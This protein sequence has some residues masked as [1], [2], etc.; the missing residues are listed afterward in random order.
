MRISCPRMPTVDWNKR[1]GRQI[2]EHVESGQ[3]FW[4]GCQWGDP[5]QLATLSAVA[6]RYIT[7]N[8]GPDTVA[9]E[10]GPGGGRWTQFLVSARELVLVDLNPEF[11]P[12][13]EERF[14][15]APAALRFYATRDSELDGIDSASI[16]F[17][18]SFGVFVHIDPD[19]IRG[20]LEHIA[21]VVRPGGLAIVQYADKTKKVAQE[22]DS[23]SDMNAMKMEAFA[24]PLFAIEGH[25]TTL[26]SHSNIIL[27]RR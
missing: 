3:D 14:K 8:V 4:W 15:D 20:Y 1:W 21:R 27:L 13:L 26:V 24:R 2:E 11:F 7:P 22:N 17:V 9:M 12:Y 18:F 25:D 6:E 10:I 16:D 19:D 5:H 23:F